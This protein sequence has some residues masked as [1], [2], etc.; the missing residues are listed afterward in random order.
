MSMN[1]RIAGFVGLGVS[2]S[3]KARSLCTGMAD[4]ARNKIFPT[5]GFAAGREGG[6]GFESPFRE[7]ARTARTRRTRRTR[8]GVIFLFQCVI[9]RMK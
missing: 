6:R 5:A 8:H 2:R 4:E 9:S 3:E 1:D 7:A